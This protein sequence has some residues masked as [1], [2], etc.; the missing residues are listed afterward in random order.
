[1]FCD[2]PSWHPD[3]GDRDN[4]YA[5]PQGLHRRYGAV[6]AALEDALG[7]EGPDATWDTLVEQRATGEVASVLTNYFELIRPHGTD[8]PQEGGREAFM[9][10]YA[11]WALREAR[12]KKPVVLVCGG[13]HVGGIRRAIARANGEKPTT[14]APSEGLRAGSYLTPFSYARL[15]SFTGY[16]S[17]M[18]SP[19]YYAQVHDHGLDAAADWAMDAITVRLRKAGLP[20]STADQ[21]AWRANAAALARLR[22][23]GSMLRADI[24]DAA[25]ATLVKEALGGPAAWT[26]DGTI[27][28][29]ADDIVVAMLQALSGEGEGRLA[30]GT[31][32][33]PLIEDIDRRLAEL[34]LTP[35]PSRKRID[36]D[37]HDP[38]DHSRAQ[39]LHQ[40]RLLDLPGV[41]RSVAP[42]AAD[43]RDLRESFEIIR[44][45]HC[46]GA[47]IEASRWGGEL[48]MAAAA[49]LRATV[50]AAPGD[51]ALL[52]SALSDGLFAG[53]FALSGDL[54]RELASSIA[55]TTRLG[56]LGKAALR[57]ARLYR[58]GDAFGPHVARDLAPVCEAVFA[59][60]LWLAEGVVADIDAR[61][62]IDAVVALRNLA[63]E[64]AGL[65]L[66]LGTA[67][68][69]FTRLLTNSQTPPALSGASLGYLIA[70]GHEDADSPDVRAGVR[71]FGTP[72]KLGDF[73]AGLFALARESMRDAAGALDV[74]DTLFACWMDEEF[75]AAF[76]SL[77]GAF[78][79]FPPRE[80][81][82][83]ARLILE[84]AGFNLAE[85]DAMAVAWMRQTAPIMDQNT[86][87]ELET[88]V[89]ERL[90]RCG[91]S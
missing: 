12:G 71:G 5:D 35:G 29:G 72:H 82:R 28:R 3:F 65:A 51:A 4:R 39:T 76:P 54:A 90:L 31:R 40:L 27:R 56:A 88:G 21:I 47:I 74:V 80:R 42:E 44:H 23:H 32:Q 68:G 58:Y 1:M 33:P 19:A 9:A 10:G 86:A 85:A 63:Q 20:V 2:L 14:P 37:W 50:I 61:D 66:D 7:T 15:D 25:L 84:R 49:R 73:L 77:R 57:L 17:G 79:W 70:L 75:L 6:L 69:V 22:A 45:P 55:R 91:L 53:L 18:P 41:T 78:A 16:A 62:A 89:G 34:D 8:D 83:L 36:I 38:A 87:M 64:G 24:L 11:A 43:A 52:A 67:R 46:M 60:A 81:E 26:R 59:H 13:L 30:P 48:P